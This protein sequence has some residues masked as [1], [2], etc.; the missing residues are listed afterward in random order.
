MIINIVLVLIFGLSIIC[1]SIVSIYKINKSYSYNSKQNIISE[2][3]NNIK[4]TKDNSTNT[5]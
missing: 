2:N 5:E 3:K 4:D 1:Q